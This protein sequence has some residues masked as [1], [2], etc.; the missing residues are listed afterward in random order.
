MDGG[1]GGT[2]VRMLTVVGDTVVRVTAVLAAGTVLIAVGLHDSTLILPLLGV[3]AVVVLLWQPAQLLTRRVEDL[4]PGEA[5]RLRRQLE[6]L[7]AEV[8]MLEATQR[9]LQATVRWQ[10]Q[11]LERLQEAPSAR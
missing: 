8:A 4:A 10:Q 11:L 1:L 6:R 3:G 7:T 2:L 5:A 9:E